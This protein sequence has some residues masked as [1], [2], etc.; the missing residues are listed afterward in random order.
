[1]ELLLIEQEEEAE[2]F[3]LDSAI[4]ALFAPDQ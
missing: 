1:M 4:P 3:A 2:T